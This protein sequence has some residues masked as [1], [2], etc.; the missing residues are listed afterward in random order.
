[1]RAT[2][3]RERLGRGVA[4]FKRS[5]RRRQRIDAPRNFVLRR[6]IN[7]VLGEVNTGFEQGNQLN[8][9]LLHRRHSV[10]QCAPHLAGG[11]AC[12]GE[13]LRIDQVPHRF[14][15]REIDAAC[16]KCAL[17]ELAG[18]RQP[19]TEFQS[20]A[21]ERFKNNRRT[22]RGNLNKIFG[23]IRVGRGKERHQR[24]VNARGF[25]L[26]GVENVG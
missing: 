20:V 18:L 14:G 16:K 13:R 5:K 24:L 12:L 22:M 6:H 17:R 9:R 25:T 4:R 1:M 11:L 21:E 3:R 8:Q 23:C 2:N 19:R 15:L 10:A 26:V 7:I